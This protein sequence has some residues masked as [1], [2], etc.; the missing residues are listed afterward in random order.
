MGTKTTL[1]QIVISFNGCVWIVKCNIQFKVE[2]K[3]KHLAFKWDS[4]QKHVGCKKAKKV[5]RRVKK[6]D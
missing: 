2:Q 1:G 3:Y 6:K 4:F 5:L